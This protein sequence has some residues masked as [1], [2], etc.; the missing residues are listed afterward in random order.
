[1]IGFLKNSAYSFPH[2]AMK[3]NSKAFLIL[4]LGTMSA[5]GP[6]IMDLYLPALPQL[7]DYFHT[8]AAFTQVS[9]MTAMIGLG[10][11]QLF[12]G[13]LSD[14]Y[15][16]KRP[17][18]ISLGVFVIT[19]FALVFSPN[20]HVL[21]TLRAIQG[22][23]AA[24][25]VVLS[26][27]VATD[28]YTG[29]ELGKFFAM[30]MTVHGLAPVLSPVAGSYLLRFTDWH[31]VFVSLTL[32]G[33]VL[34]TAVLFLVESLPPERRFDSS[35]FKSFTVYPQ[36]LKNSTFMGFVL[37]QSFGFAGLFAYISAS[38][39]IF[40]SHFGLSPT[41]FS[42]CFGANGLAVMIGA[43]IS[44]RI[45]RSRA[46]RFGVTVFTL[47]TLY[48]AVAL[49]EGFSIGFIEP[50]FF[51]M[52]LSLGFIFP[53]VSMQAMSSE[54]KNAGS[55]SAL[56]GFCPFMLG[57]ICS[58]LVGIGNLFVSTGIVLSIA[59]L[60]VCGMYWRVRHRLTF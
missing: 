6:F 56:L 43:N 42:A 55:A 59:G 9:L 57:A 4:L 1:M 20:I 36:I 39:F 60:A 46:L 32:L 5:F 53:I 34:I 49:I 25:S 27:A 17:L 50:G 14:K 16:R 18:L 7:R 48:L 26:R 8:S 23:S 52:T 21:I 29:R 54:R 45:N 58:P 22:F 33:L 12:I 37:M 13:P 40:Q 47:A 24:G 11:G 30:L 44:T 15:G 51:C 10:V 41:E 3:K 35:I 19:S 2:I 28:L 38:P 31:G